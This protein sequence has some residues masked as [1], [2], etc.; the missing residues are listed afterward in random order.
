MSQRIDNPRYMN[1][2]L[3]IAGRI[4]NGEF[5]EGERIFGRSTMASEYNVSPETIRRAV[6]LLEDMQ[7]VIPSQGSGIHIS[8]RSNAY[9]FVKKFQNKETI[10]SLKNEIKDLL[11]QKKNIEDS[12]N[13]RIEKIVDYSDRLKNLNVLIP[14]EIEIEDDSQLIGHTISETKFW[15]HTG[16]TVIAIQRKGALV[17]SPGPYGG[18]EKGDTVFVIGGEDVIQRVKQFMKEYQ[19]E[20]NSIS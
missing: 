13:D 3:D 19:V 6:N 5:R 16:A 10:R 12:I 20:D 2:A 17:L 15:Q 14:L 11:F 18:F 7:V 8:S 9:A 4:C 1:I